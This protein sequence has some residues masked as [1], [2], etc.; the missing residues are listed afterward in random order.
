[1]SLM[2]QIGT[3]ASVGII[4]KVARDTMRSPRK[5]RKRK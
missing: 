2:N 5:K 4:S 1:M 3:I